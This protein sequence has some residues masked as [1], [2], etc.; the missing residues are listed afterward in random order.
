MPRAAYDLSPFGQEHFGNADLGHCWRT[1]SLVDQANRLVRHPRGALPEK[2]HDPNA[3]RRLYDLMNTKAVTPAAVLKPS[4]QRTAELVLQQRGVVLALHDATELAFTGHTSLQDQVG[5]IGNGHGRG[6][7][8]HNSLA[9][10]PSRQ[11]LGLL[12]QYLP[13]RAE[14]PKDE[15]AAQRRE[16]EDRERLLGLHG[17]AAAPQ[18]VPEACWRQGRRERPEGLLRVDVCDRG[19]D[20]FEFLDSEDRLGRH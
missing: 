9:V 5:P 3:L 17:A 6:Y 15:T 7:L 16:R 14:V 20:P 1:A 19:G 12:G 2:L 10:L 18:A 8:C 4:V 13:V 11:V